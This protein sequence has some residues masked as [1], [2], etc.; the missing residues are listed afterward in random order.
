MPEIPREVILAAAN[1]YVGV[2]ETITGGF[3]WPDR[4]VAPL[5]RIR[6]NLKKFF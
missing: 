1:V 6:A 2:C 3:A 4:N 5:A